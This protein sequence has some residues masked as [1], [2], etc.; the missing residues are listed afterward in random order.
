MPLPSFL[1]TQGHRVKKAG[2]EMAL[3]FLPLPALFTAC[4][5]HRRDCLPVF[6]SK[7]RCFRPAIFDAFVVS[8]LRIFSQV[9]NV[10]PLRLQPE[11]LFTRVRKSCIF[12]RQIHPEHRD[13]I[14]VHPQTT[15]GVATDQPLRL[16]GRI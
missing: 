16:Q 1:I 3:L 12:R 14:G 11:S 8:I 6:P 2:P 10:G 13:A 4:Q 15:V 9:R 7:S 5:D